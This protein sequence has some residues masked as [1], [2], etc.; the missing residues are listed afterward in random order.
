MIP[1]INTN[2]TNEIKKPPKVKRAATATWNGVKVASK[3][4]GGKASSATKKVCS[5]IKTASKKVWGLRKSKVA[6]IVAGSIAAAATTITAIGLSALG[7]TLI[8]KKAL[9]NKRNREIQKTQEEN[10]PKVSPKFV[11]AHEELQRIFGGE[12]HSLPI[13]RKPIKKQEIQPDLQR[14]RLSHPTLLRPKREGIKKPSRWEN[15]TPQPER[16]E[17]QPKYDDAVIAKNLQ[18]IEISKENKVI[19]QIAND[20]AIGHAMIELDKAFLTERQNQS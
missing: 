12:G 4:V 13:I 10:K 5:G 7:I 3:C 17:I 9:K 6:L 8:T 15:P 16:C 1:S 20:R 11:K 14:Q 19:E 2:T 18:Q